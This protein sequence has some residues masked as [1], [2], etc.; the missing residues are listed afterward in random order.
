MR[1]AQYRKPPKKPSGNTSFD[2][3]IQFKK[4]LATYTD[5]EPVIAKTTQ[6][7]II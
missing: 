7:M 4:G 5:E 6:I 3:P 1:N 2:K